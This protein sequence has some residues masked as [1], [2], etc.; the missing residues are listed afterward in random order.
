MQQPFKMCNDRYLHLCTMLPLT[1][2]D[3]TADT[4]APTPAALRA[5]LTC[6][7]G[8]WSRW[9]NVMSMCSAAVRYATLSRYEL[10]KTER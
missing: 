6:N 10:E 7:S 8:A 1:P 9:F 3:V 5:P 2:H 4:P